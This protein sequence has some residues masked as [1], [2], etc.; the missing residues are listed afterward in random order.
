MT[1]TELD[2]VIFAAK[3]P[4]D[5]FSRWEDEKS[6]FEREVRDY[7]L[8]HPRYLEFEISD[9]NVPD[10]IAKLLGRPMDGSCWGHYRTNAA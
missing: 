2:Q 5:V 4:E 3:R 1:F 9:P 10:L 6:R 7:F 8:G